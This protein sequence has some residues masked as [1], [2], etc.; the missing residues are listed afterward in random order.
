MN[1]RVLATAC[2]KGREG[3]RSDQAWGFVSRIMVR[4]EGAGSA[5][6]ASLIGMRGREEVEG[7]GT[8]GAGFVVLCCVYGIHDGYCSCRGT[9]VSWSRN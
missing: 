7:R 6:L 1:T 5:S 9:A 2:E 4:R 8:V 3:S